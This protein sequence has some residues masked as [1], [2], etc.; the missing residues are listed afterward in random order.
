MAWKINYNSVDKII[1]LDYTDIVTPD[2]LQS[3]FE[4]SVKLSMEHKTFLLRADC[5]NLKGGHTLFDLLKIIEQISNLD[6]LRSIKEAVILSPG[7]M[8]N[9]MNLEFW[10]TACRNRGISVKL[11]DDNVK[12]TEWLKS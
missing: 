12:A 8:P 7:Q 4:S 10:E 9:L 6:I 11:F 5:R 2:E 3:A 1:E